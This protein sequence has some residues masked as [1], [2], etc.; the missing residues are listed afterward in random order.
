MRPE[1]GG[2]LRA[3]AEWERHSCTWIAWPHNESTFPPQLIGKVEE[4]YCEIVHEVARGEA[5][6]ILVNDEDEAERVRKLLEEAGAPLWNVEFH[7]V[8]TEDV[9]VRDYGPIFVKN[10]GAGVLCGVK[11]RFNAWGMKYPELARDD[12]AGLQILNLAG[13]VPIYRNYVVEGGAIEVSGNGILLTTEQCLLDPDRNPGL[14]R[15]DLEVE[16]HRYLGTRDV[17]W[18]EM[19]VVGDDT[20]GH[21]DVFCRFTSPLRVVLAEEERENMNKRIL[22]RAYRKLAGY[23]EEK[24]AGI[25][26]VRVPCP[27]PIKVLDQYIPASYLNFYIANS[28][29]LVPVFGVEEDESALAILA[30]CFPHR[31]VVGIFCK[32]LFYGLGGIHCVTI[33]QPSTEA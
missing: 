29:V 25:E 24:G 11:W 15:K 4:A 18:F 10:E 27:P 26:I 16:F 7:K 9:W 23:I 5:V 22:E 31:R 12:K 32:E 2:R 19:G 3:P 14:G 17:I 21:V 6:K 30:D 13:T 33:Q 8:P 28:A 1:D 20:D